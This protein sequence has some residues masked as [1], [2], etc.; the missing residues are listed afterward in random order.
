MKIGVINLKARPDRLE[1]FS[2]SMRGMKFEVI[3]A[4]DHNDAKNE[5]W[6]PDKIWRIP[7]TG[8]ITSDAEVACFAS[9]HRAWGMCERNNEPLLILEDD[10]IPIVEPRFHLYEQQIQQYDIL[11]LG[12][13]E[14]IPEKI[15]KIGDDLVIPRYP[16]W[17]SSYIITPKGAS[18]LINATTPKNI[19]PADEFVPLMIGYDHSDSPWRL[20][21]HSDW[22]QVMG[23][24]NKLKAAALYKPDFVQA[25]AIAR[26]GMSFGYDHGVLPPWSSSINAKEN[27][28]ICPSRP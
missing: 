26:P 27:L 20:R 16:Y 24:H 22:V 8:K 19:I 12:Y 18:M 10:A 7:G 23:K 5:G 9:H 14:N 6:A 11:F 21:S 4:L 28:Y 17:L 2:W 15:K 3:H 25:G 1:A 13:K